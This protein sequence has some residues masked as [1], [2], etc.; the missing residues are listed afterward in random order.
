[1]I[2]LFNCSCIKNVTLQIDSDKVIKL[3]VSYLDDKENHWLYMEN[4]S[5]IAD[6]QYHK[7]KLANAYSTIKAALVGESR[8][9]EIEL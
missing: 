8:F 7:D 6:K 4:I 5:D 9:V 1:M 2:Q 3:Q